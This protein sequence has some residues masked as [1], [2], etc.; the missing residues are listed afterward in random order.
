VQVLQDEPCPPRR[1]V[2][3]VAFRKKDRERNHMGVS[4][5]IWSAIQWG[6]QRERRADR[7]PGR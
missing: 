4:F 2:V 7:S 6:R 5:A 3:D 1:I